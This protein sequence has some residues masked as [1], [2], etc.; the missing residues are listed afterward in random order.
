V[1]RACFN[2][3]RCCFVAE[4]LHGFFREFFEV[5]LSILGSLYLAL[6]FRRRDLR[7]EKAVLKLSSR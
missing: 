1:D 2:A 5:A 6:N 7:A 3:D 4:A